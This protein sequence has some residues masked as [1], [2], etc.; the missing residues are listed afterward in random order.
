MP[1]RGNGV[2]RR[3]ALWTFRLSGWWIEGEL[4]NLPQFVIVGAPHRSAWEFWLAMM[5]IYGLGLRVNWMAKDSL[6]FWPIGGI[7]RWLGGI[8]IDRRAHHGVVPQSVEAFRQRP[9]MILALAPEGTR[10]KAGCP[11][12]E[13]KSGYY[14]IAYGAGVPIVPAYVDYAGKRLIL[15]PSFEPSGDIDADVQKLQAFYDQP[16]APRRSSAARNS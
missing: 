5:S 11:V 1:R 16:R 15:G 7:M 9:Q 14:H 3:L 10:A 4:P 8:A 2:T 12:A 6:F 13:W